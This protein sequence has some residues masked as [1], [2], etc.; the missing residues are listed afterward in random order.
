MTQ[1]RPPPSLLLVGICKR[2]LE[3]VNRPLFFLFLFFLLFSLFFG[4][5]G[6]GEGGYFFVLFFSSFF[7]SEI[8]L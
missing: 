8:I 2:E 4:G 6:R 1:L 7:K 5:V 3:V